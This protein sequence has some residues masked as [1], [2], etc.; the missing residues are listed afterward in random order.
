MARPETAIPDEI[1]D[2]APG[3]DVKKAAQSG[4][5]SRQELKQPVAP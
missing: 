3:G 4:L 2:I 5:A 1:Y